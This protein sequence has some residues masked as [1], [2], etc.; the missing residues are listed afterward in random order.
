MQAAFPDKE[1][2]LWA[3]KPREHFFFDSLIIP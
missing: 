1:N 3:V 2:A